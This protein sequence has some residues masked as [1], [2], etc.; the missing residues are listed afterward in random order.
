MRIA[1]NL[2]V[3]ALVAGFAT[4]GLA[5]PAAAD[6]YKGHRYEKTSYWQHEY[7]AD[8]CE[9]KEYEHGVKYVVL[10]DKN[11]KKD[12]EVLVLKGKYDHKVKVIEDPKEYKKYYLKHGKI[13]WSIECWDKDKKDK[14]HHEKEREHEKDYAKV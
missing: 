14:K 4:A 6:D 3:G 12:F 1:R 5:A 9:K 13:E 2:A 8:K 11:D 7:K 10:H